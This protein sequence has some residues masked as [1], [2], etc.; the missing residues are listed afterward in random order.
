MNIEVS[1]P[2]KSN[3]V[4]KAKLKLTEE[5]KGNVRACIINTLTAKVV[6]AGI[7]DVHSLKVSFDYSEDFVTDEVTLKAF[8]D[9][10]VAFA[11]KTMKDLK[12][13]AT[14]DRAVQLERRVTE[15]EKQLADVQRA[16][17]CEINALKIDSAVIKH[18]IISKS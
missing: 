16:T 9:R 5:G 17:S 10:A 1:M 6:V 7:S 4:D 18:A 8:N 13:S 12:I 3:R 15:L 14:D 2:Q 11:E